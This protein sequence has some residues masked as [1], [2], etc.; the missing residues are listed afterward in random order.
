MKRQFTPMQYLEAVRRH[1][2]SRVKAAE[3][4]DVSVRALL[5]NLD[6]CRE[7]GEEIP[8]SPYH[9]GRAEY[10]RSQA[11]AAHKAAPDHFHVK[12]VSTLYGPEG[13][14]KQQWVKT[15]SDDEEASTTA[16]EGQSLEELQAL[17]KAK[18]MD[19]KATWA[20]ADYGPF[21]RGLSKYMPDP[22]TPFNESAL[23]HERAVECL[24]ELRQRR[25][26][27]P[28]SA[29]AGHGEE[30]GDVAGRQRGVHR[31]E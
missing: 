2:G 19:C 18:V 23:T 22:K 20:A 25:G 29:F 8:D 15:R 10:L 28:V 27:P 26:E 24:A 13:E 6:L 30:A 1:G 21:Y 11:E 7:R 3:E 31:Q 9:T 14:I 17:I 4:L 5:K 12:G 16:P